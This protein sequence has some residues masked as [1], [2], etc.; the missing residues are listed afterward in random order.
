MSDNT[1]LHFL[2]IAKQLPLEQTE[3]D[4][5]FRKFWTHIFIFARELYN[6]NSWR[7]F[8]FFLLFKSNLFS[9][10]VFA[11]LAGMI[12]FGSMNP[13]R[14]AYFI[15]TQSARKPQAQSG[16]LSPTLLTS[17]EKWR[18]LNC[19]YFTI[20]VNY[21]TLSSF[22]LWWLNRSTQFE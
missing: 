12:D 14:G 4:L 17:T 18:A 21:F 3:L 6:S 15:G 8:F 11:K 16:L 7:N 20:R 9:V 1:I 19:N 13:W 22:I 2:R 5:K 10:E